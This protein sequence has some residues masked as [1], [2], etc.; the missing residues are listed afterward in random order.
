MQLIVL[1]PQPSVKT[2]Q[3]QGLLCLQSFQ[4]REDSED[5]TTSSL[6][7]FLLI[8]A[9]FFS[10]MFRKLNKTDKRCHCRGLLI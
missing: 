5:V 7:L 6:I 3:N 8:V 2:Q 10:A 9:A 4:D 1:R